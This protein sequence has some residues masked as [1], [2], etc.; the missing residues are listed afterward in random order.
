MKLINLFFLSLLLLT[1]GCDDEDVLPALADVAPPSE[2]SL[3]FDIAGDNSGTVSI[4]PNGRGVTNY[5]LDFGDGSDVLTEVQPGEVIDHVY[6]LGTYNVSLTAMGI[7]GLTASTSQELTVSFLPP[8]NLMVMITPTNGNNLG[9]DVTATADLETIFEVYFG[10]D[11]TAAPL[12]FVEGETVSYTYQNIGTYDVRVVAISGGSASIEEITSVE[13]TNPLLLPVDFEDATQTYE[14]IG[15]GQASGEVVDNPASSEVNNS[16]KVAKLTKPAGSETWAGVTLELGQAIDF[17]GLDK[18][19]LATW[20]PRA[21]V[22]VLL[23][24]ENGTDGDIFVEALATTT[25]AGSWE[26]LLFDFSSADLSGEYQKVIVFYDF[27]ASGMNEI[28][29]YDAIE[30]TDGQGEILLPVSFEEDLGITFDGFGGANAEVIDNPDASGINTSSKVGQFIKNIGS[31]T[32][33]GIFFDV[34]GPID[35]SATQLVKVKIWSPTAGVDVILKI[36]DPTDNT[37]NREA[38]VATTVSGQW[39]ELTFDLSGI[40]DL[41]NMSRIVL[42]C[43]FGNGGTEEPYYFD[44]IRL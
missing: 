9:I 14:L 19:K 42:F 38:T 10:E 8:E 4:Q 27:D 17:N 26:E 5:S 35:F 1:F 11:D 34:S 15:F 3:A 31:E 13:I 32:W 12:T 7:N 22:P 24:L 29:Y 21:N 28:F 44:D 2:L 23:K 39:E 40:Q 36:E 37:I 20:S 16:S 41:A 30:L 6:A 25:S 33:G 18:I 43:D